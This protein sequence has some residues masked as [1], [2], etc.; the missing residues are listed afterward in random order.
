MR[1]SA[2]FT[3]LLEGGHRYNDTRFVIYYRPNTA[4]GARLGLAVS[5]R[6]ARKATRRNQ[7]KRLLRETFRSLSWRLPPLDIFVLLKPLAATV[8][9]TELRTSVARAFD[10]L[11]ANPSR[12]P[13][14][15]KR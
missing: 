1:A 6:V 9:G 8:D 2:D 3:A 12:Q 5:K 10:H 4:N 14:P 15:R 7:L 13:T 11:N